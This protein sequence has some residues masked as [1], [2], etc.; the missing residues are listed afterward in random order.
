MSL[1]DKIKFRFEYNTDKPCSTC[2]GKKDCTDYIHRK[3]I[4]HNDIWPDR[5]T[6]N[7]YYRGTSKHA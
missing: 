1:T 4:E 7:F 5:Y 2:I 6:C 3:H